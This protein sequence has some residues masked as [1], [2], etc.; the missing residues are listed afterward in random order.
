MK[1]G[2]MQPYFVPYL[3]YWQLMNAVDK[4]VIYDD[5]NYIKGGWINR[6]HILINGEAV[7]INLVLNGA[8][9]FKKINEITIS[10]DK[11]VHEKLLKTIQNAYRR[12]PHFDEVYSLIQT[13]LNCKDKNLAGILANSI[14]VIHDYLGMS[15]ELILSSELDKN[16]E[17]KG[18]DK[19]LHICELLKADQYYNAIGGIEL[20]D[21]DEF[22][23]HGITLHFLKT[24]AVA[25]QQFAD[26]FVPNLSILDVLMF[27]SK[28]E[29]EVLLTKYE[30]V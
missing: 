10:D 3:G 28:K 18:C 7:R 15:S 19:V 2:I 8:S 14:R 11:K 1:V 25:Y 29:V 12:A 27:N 23:Q 20:Y 21:R 30:L 5:V 6:N 13:I 16:N 17:L 9:S 24:H 26:R 4:Y 22:K